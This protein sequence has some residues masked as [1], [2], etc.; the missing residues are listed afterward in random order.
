MSTTDR[1]SGDAPSARA[2]VTP[3]TVPAT[4][5]DSTAPEH[6]R[7]LKYDLAR[8]GR[9][10]AQFVLAATFQKD[11]SFATQDE[12]ERIRRGVW[13]ASFLGGG[14]LTVSV[15][16]VAAEAEEVRTAL[17]ACAEHARREG[18]RF[19]VDGPVAI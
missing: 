19:D 4:A 7:D 15:G 13:A 9:V 6:L 2:D 3:V 10:P 5:L 12:A 16:E 14:R 18:V 17:R 11:C 1:K 8:E